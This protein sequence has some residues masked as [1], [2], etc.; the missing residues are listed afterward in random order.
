M[1]NLVALQVIASHYQDDRYVTW[2]EFRE[3]MEAY[4]GDVPSV[5]DPAPDPAPDPTPEPP[6]FKPDNWV[7]AIHDDGRRTGPYQLQSPT[8]QFGQ[9]VWSLSKYRR[10]FEN[11][12]VHATDAEKFRP[13]AVAGYEGPHIEIKG[14]VW[15]FESGVDKVRFRFIDDHYW[16]VKYCTL[17]TA[18][19]DASQ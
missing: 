18:A 5:P 16:S 2:R 19:P 1:G 3:T 11:H 7:M 10:W 17:I 13:G 14:E 8:R 4:H 15:T 9:R 12:L 6:E